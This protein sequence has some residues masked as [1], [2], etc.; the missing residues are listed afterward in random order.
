MDPSTEEQLSQCRDLYYAGYFRA[1]LRASDALRLSDAV[2]AVTLEAAQLHY[3]SSLALHQGG[4]AEV[5]IA[6]LLQQEEYGLR[7]IGLI[8]TLINQQASEEVKRDALARLKAQSSSNALSRLLTAEALARQTDFSEALEMVDKGTLET[9]ALRVFLCLH[10]NRPDVAERTLAE[11]TTMNDE[12]GVTRTASAWLYLV[13]GNFQEAYLT[14]SDVQ[15]QCCQEDP[16]DGVSCQ[17]LNGKAVSNMLRKQWQEA[18]EDL[19]RALDH[20]PNNED[21][22]ANSICCAQNRRQQEEASKHFR[23]LASVSPSHPFVVKAE[24]VRQAFEAFDHQ[25]Q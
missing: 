5:Q 8:Y 14:Y 3:L 18:T 10:I 23:T 4:E 11:M 16:E 9:K 6:Q 15:R 24:Q 7:A 12:A 1:C 20:D 2:D 21:A 22:L 17:M 25:R 19:H 13:S